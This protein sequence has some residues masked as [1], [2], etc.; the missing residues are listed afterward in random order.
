M[1]GYMWMVLA[2][3][4]IVTGISITVAVA[5]RLTLSRLTAESGQPDVMPA[6]HPGGRWPGLPARPSATH[7]GRR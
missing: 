5:A 3:A 2:V 6:A 1:G 4:E 7:S